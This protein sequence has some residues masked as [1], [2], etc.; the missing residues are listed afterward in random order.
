MKIIKMY[1]GF[2]FL[3]EDDEAENIAKSYNSN[4]LLKLRCGDRIA[5]KGIEAICDPELIPYWNDY[6]LEKSGNSFIRDGQRVKLETKDFN[7]I[8]YKPHPKYEA[9]SRI[10]SEKMQMLSHGQRTIASEEAAKL[11][12]GKK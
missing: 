2:E 5:P 1:S 3:V 7:Q 9:M 10:L 12:R 4:S 6:M 11:E 8:E